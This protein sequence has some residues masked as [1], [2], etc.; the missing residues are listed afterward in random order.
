M[1]NMEIAKIILDQLGG[2][3]FLAMTGSKNLLALDNGLRI[4]LSRNQTKANRLEIILT[5]MDTYTMKFYRLAK[6]NYDYQVEEVKALDMVY[7]DN[8]QFLFTSVTGL[9]TRL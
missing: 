8:L 7:A 5:S 6:K 2:N 4:D 1:D 3:K 9:D